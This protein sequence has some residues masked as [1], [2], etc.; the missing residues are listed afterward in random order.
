ML[1]GIHVDQLVRQHQQPCNAVATFI[2]LAAL[3]FPKQPSR[4]RNRKVY[5]FVQ[6]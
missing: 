1:A 6:A 3:L 4:G 5:A 2:L